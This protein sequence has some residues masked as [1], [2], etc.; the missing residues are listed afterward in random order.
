MACDAFIVWEDC[1][2]PNSSLPY[3]FTWKAWTDKE[4]T[5]L[6]DNPANVDISF[7]LNIASE[8]EDDTTPIVLGLITVDVTNSKIYVLLTG[9]TAGISYD[10]TCRI[11]A[12]NG[13]IEDQTAVL[14]CA[15]K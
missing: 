7:T 11:T 2:D 15:E 6:V 4:Q 8:G 3:S 14:H 5:T 12:A 13:F 1:K 10:V 9:G